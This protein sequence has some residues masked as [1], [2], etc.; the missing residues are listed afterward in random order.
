MNKNALAPDFFFNS[1]PS[2]QADVEAEKK[3]ATDEERA[4][5]ALKQMKG[6]VILKDFIENIHSDLNNVNKTAIASGASLEEIGRNAI[7]ISMTQE[8]IER[9]LNKVSDATEACTG[10]EQ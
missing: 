3:G 1:L 5:F 6:W 8:I 4:L 9:I 2:M 10:D 7:V